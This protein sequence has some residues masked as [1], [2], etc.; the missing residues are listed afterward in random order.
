MTS[1]YCTN[2]TFK[3]F[4]IPVE[5]ASACAMYPH[6]LLYRPQSILNE[7]YTNLIQFTHPARGGHFAA[8]EEPELFADDVWGFVHKREQM[9]VDERRQK[10]KKLKEEQQRKQQM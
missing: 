6:E 3:I 7:Q 8:F 1:T 4:R 2:E 9:L 5:V 10:A